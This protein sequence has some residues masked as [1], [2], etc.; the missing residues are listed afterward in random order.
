LYF[1]VLT[2]AVR[3]SQQVISLFSVFSHFSNHDFLYSCTCMYFSESYFCILRNI[4]FFCGSLDRHLVGVMLELELN[5]L[6]K[7]PKFKMLTWILKC[8]TTR[9]AYHPLHE[10]A[11]KNIET[12]EDINLL[13]G[14]CI[15]K[16]YYLSL[17]N[18]PG[19]L[20]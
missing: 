1:Q 5:D 10:F 12:W 13:L 15:F 6:F 11:W 7:L 19:S 17:L 18:I 16:P 14:L 4:F 20:R 2:E 8:I 3:F 9:V